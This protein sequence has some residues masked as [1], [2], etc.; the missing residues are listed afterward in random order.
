MIKADHYTPVDE[1]LIPTGEIASVEET[2]FDFRNPTEI[3]TRLNSA[4]EQLE[5]GNGYDH[6]FVCKQGADGAAE[7]IAHVYS[8]RTGIFMELISSEP[9][10]QFYGGNFLDGKS[11][12]KGGTP[13]IFRSALC[14]EPQHFPDSP[15]QPDFPSTVLNP[16]E[17]YQHS[18]LYKFSIK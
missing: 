1:T 6:N 14:L 17:T 15:N 5:F 13:Y 3:G 12:G 10:L 8:P 11:Q 9:G 2:P 7:V 18:I 16:D 4:N